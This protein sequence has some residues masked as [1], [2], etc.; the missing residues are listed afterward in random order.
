MI[1]NTGSGIIFLLLLHFFSV[2]A[3]NDSLR[4]DST[5]GK[6]CLSGFI[7]T[8]F[9]LNKNWKE[10]NNS[11][12]LLSLNLRYQNKSTV[13][14][15]SITDIFA[16]LSY[17]KFIDSIWVKNNDRFFFSNIFQLDHGKIRQTISIN[18]TSQIT[19]TWIESETG[20]PNQRLWKSG[21]LIPAT[22]VTGYGFIY[23]P[24]PYNYIN[25]SFPSYKIGTLP[26]DGYYDDDLKIVK[27][28]E[29]YVMYHQYG[30]QFQMC[31][32]QKISSGIFFESS[33]NI[34]IEQRLFKNI[35]FDVRN[36]LSIYP[37]KN[38]KLRIEN[39]IVYD[40]MVSEA[41]QWKYD[42]LFGVSVK[43]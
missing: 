42:F 21:P 8:T 39:K 28:S 18:F 33:S 27:R 34:F 9:L 24:M 36:T 6:S 12:I 41:F 15:K 19:D 11:S 14:T 40:K 17:I 10:M 38:F 5:G 20:S 22:I 7:A 37:L 4:A 35:Y 32:S 29:K 23:K 3:Q 31:V 30:L 13:K 16:E 1:R 26:A 25:I 43:I 2:S